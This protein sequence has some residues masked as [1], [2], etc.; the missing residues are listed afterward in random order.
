M[1]GSSPR[2]TKRRGRVDSTQLH[3]PLE[4]YPFR[5][6]RDAYFPGA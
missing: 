3:Q 2:M 4:R 6:N 5:L 1:R